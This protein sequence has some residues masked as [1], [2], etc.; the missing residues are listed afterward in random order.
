MS[1][2]KA[3]LSPECVIGWQ[4]GLHN[5]VS[6][7]LEWSRQHTTITRLHLISRPSLALSWFFNILLSWLDHLPQLLWLGLCQLECSCLLQSTPSVAATRQTNTYPTDFEQGWTQIPL[8]LSKRGHIWLGFSLLHW[9]TWA[10]DMSHYFSYLLG[11]A[12]CA[13]LHLQR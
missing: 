4:G 8:S 13:C 9:A 11:L 7:N 1:L 5:W 3:S 12:N 6:F 2:D 10:L